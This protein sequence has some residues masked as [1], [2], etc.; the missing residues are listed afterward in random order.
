MLTKHS[1]LCTEVKAIRKGSFCLLQ[2]VVLKT[3][4]VLFAET[5]STVTKL[6][7]IS[8]AKGAQL[9]VYEAYNSLIIVCSKKRAQFFFLLPAEKGFS[10]PG[11]TSHHEFPI[12]SS[13]SLPRQ[14]TSLQL[15]VA[16]LSPSALYGLS[17]FDLVSINALILEWSHARGPLRVPSPLTPQNE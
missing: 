8:Q 16:I 14:N 11:T 17:A 9:A 7:D 13:L 3:G 4:Q 6:Q 5:L 2:V 1:L 15:L 10:F 12:I